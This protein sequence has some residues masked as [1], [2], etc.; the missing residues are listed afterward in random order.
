MAAT[1]LVSDGYRIAVRTYVSTYA[2]GPGGLRPS[3]HQCVASSVCGSR[4]CASG[5][6]TRASGHRLLHIACECF[7][8]L[9]RCQ[10]WRRKFLRA[11]E[12][13]HDRY[14]RLCGYL[15]IRLTNAPINVVRYR[16]HRRPIGRLSVTDRDVVEG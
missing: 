11:G 16:P 4:C 5:L 8:E 15:Q 13:A 1:L 10:G 2:V 12:R 9:R 6:G 7:H 14:V 3:D